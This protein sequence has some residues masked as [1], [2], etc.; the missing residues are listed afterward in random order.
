[1]IVDLRCPECFMWMQECCTRDEL[2]E[3]DK[4]QA[5]SRELLVDA[6]E[7]SVAESME[8]LADCFGGG[9]GARPRRRGRLR[10]AAR[11]FA[12]RASARH[13]ATAA[14]TSS[15]SAPPISRGR[16]SGKRSGWRRNSQSRADALA[17]AAPPASRG[18]AAR[19]P[20]RHLDACP[21]ASSRATRSASRRPHR[22]GPADRGEHVGAHGEPVRVG[23]GVARPGRRGGGVAG[24]LR[25]VRPEPAGA[26]RSRP[27]PVRRPRR[28]GPRRRGACPAARPR[29]YPRP[30]ANETSG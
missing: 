20:R 5:A 13:C 7:R 30:S 12:R 22:L 28:A 9:A 14:S 26:L 11:G 23:E 27:A 17:V 19:R 15:G 4:R 24:R 25:R 8:A 18:A 2:A 3:L 21:A 1:M 16:G 6:Y 10:A 29:A